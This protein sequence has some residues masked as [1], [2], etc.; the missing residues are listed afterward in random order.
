MT[1]PDFDTIA[2]YYDLIYADRTDDIE[3]WLALAAESGTDILEIGC[4]TG[5]V[6]IPL[7]EAGFRVTGI[8][9]SADALAAAQ[10]KIDAGDFGEQATL[11]QADM[12]K[13]SLSRT[14]FDMAFIPIN[15]IMHCLTIADQQSTLK[16]VHRHLRPGGWLVVDVYHPYPPALAEADGRVELAKQFTTPDGNT[17]QWFVSRQLQLD[18]QIQQVT[19]LLD[20]MDETGNMRRHTLSFPMRYV[21]RFEMELLL[22]GT[23]FAVAEI[24]GDYD[25][26]LFYA[27]SPR[28]IFLAQ[29]K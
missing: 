9:L 25:Q 26:S 23:G 15:T 13:F 24:L 28:M 1:Q 7:L 10:K 27:E 4:G 2:R 14:D 16:T 22:N 17:M 19:F 18:E 11:V 29:K 21:H 3:M 5:R 8:D 12:R 6:T 20:E